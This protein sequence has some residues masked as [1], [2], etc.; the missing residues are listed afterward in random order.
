MLKLVLYLIFG[1]V[2]VLFT[3]QNL[4]PVPVNL[5]AGPEFDV[6]LIVIIGISFFAGFAFAM[7][8]V[9]RKTIRGGG[10]R[11]AGTA[12]EPWRSRQ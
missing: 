3:S 7:L 12:V 1:A 6:P 10:K 11:N 9:I 8:A 4:E 2:I 5:I